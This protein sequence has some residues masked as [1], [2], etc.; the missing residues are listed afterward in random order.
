MT[1]AEDP[2][3]DMTDTLVAH[4]TDTEI[5]LDT[6]ALDPDLRSTA[7]GVTVATTHIEVDQDH[8][9]NIH[10][11]TSHTIEVPATTATIVIHPTAGTPEMPPETSAVCTIGPGNTSTNQPK[12]PHHLHGKVPTGNINKSQ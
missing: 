10:A 9:T 12:Y 5:D 6:V 8:S 1:E 4:A 7:I 3:P 11:A 2:L